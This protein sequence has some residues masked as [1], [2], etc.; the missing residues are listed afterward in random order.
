MDSVSLINKNKNKIFNI[1]LIIIALFVALNIYKKQ[2]ANID[3]LKANIVEEEK[4]NWTLDNIGKLDAKIDSYRKLLPRKERDSS[5]NDISNIARNSGIKITGIR[6]S[7]EEVFPDY[8]KYIFD[9]AIISPDYDS[10][11]RFI[12]TLENN[13]NVYM[14]NALDIRSPSYNREKEL[15]A[16]LRLSTVAILE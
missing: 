7:G 9:L 13:Q 14:V 2:M 11:A 10:L 16:S 4:K 12:N 5:I 3:Y 15:N 8:T 6:P 1:V